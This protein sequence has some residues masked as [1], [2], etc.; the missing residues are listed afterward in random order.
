MGEL[1]ECIGDSFAK[2]RI[3][4]VDEEQRVRVRTLVF[5]AIRT[6]RCTSIGDLLAASHQRPMILLLSITIGNA[7]T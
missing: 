5:F 4:S 7:E 2:V 3:A 6:V 1:L